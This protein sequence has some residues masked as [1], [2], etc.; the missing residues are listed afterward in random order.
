[1]VPRRFFSDLIDHQVGP[2]FF[3]MV[4]GTGIIGSQLTQVVGNYAAAT[5]LWLLA[6]LLWMCLIYTIFVGL[7]I[8]ETKL[9]I[10]QGINGGWLI[11]IVATQSVATL[12]GLLASHLE[13]YRQAVLFLALAM[14]LFGG[15]F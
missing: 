8:K 3:T 13:P 1:M 14:W 11:A 10:D 12:G 5:L 2:A 9:P 6:L 7:T 15:M 4:A